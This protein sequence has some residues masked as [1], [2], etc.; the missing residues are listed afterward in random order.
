[1]GMPAEDTALMLRYAQDGDM[2]AFET[3]YSRHK[4]PLYRYL[5]RLSG[6]RDNA[7]DLCQEVWSKVIRARAGYRPTAKFSTWL[8]RIAHNAFIDQVRRNR[9]YDDRSAD[10]DLLADPGHGPEQGAERRRL[11]ERLFAA[12]AGLPEEQRDAFLLQEEAGLTLDEIA[13]VTG[14]P[15]ETAKSRLRYAAAK[16]RK[17][18]AEPAAPLEDA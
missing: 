3:L 2:A 16:L 10:P 18:L 12:L 9:R 14:V 15:R 4:D 7:A 8:Y 17:A 11:R 13:S 6:Q 1:M 5:L